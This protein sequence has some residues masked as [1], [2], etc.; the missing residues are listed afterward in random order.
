MKS[1]C[2]SSSSGNSAITSRQAKHEIQFSSSSM[3]PLNICPM[4]LSYFSLSSC[5]KTNITILLWA[6]S[7]KTNMKQHVCFPNKMAMQ[8]TLLQN[9]S[10]YTSRLQPSDMLETPLSLSLHSCLILGPNWRFGVLHCPLQNKVR[11]GSAAFWKDSKQREHRTQAFRNLLNK[12]L[13]FILLSLCRHRKQSSRIGGLLTPG[14]SCPVGTH[15]CRD[16]TPRSP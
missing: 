1:C 11:R 5:H 15:P 12:D 14:Q 2:N 4:Y 9:M 13:L 7:Y 10:K 3:F 6:N 16:D 8:S